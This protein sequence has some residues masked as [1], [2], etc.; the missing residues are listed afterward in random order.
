[1]RIYIPADKKGN[2]VT[3]NGIIGTCENWNTGGKYAIK[4]TQGSFN[5][6]KEK[7]TTLEKQVHS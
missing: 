5:P 7:G 4:K 2:N 1:L 6:L 3:Y